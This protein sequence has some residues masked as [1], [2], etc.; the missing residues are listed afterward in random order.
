MQLETH[1]KSLIRD[2]YRRAVNQGDIAFAEQLIADDYIQHSNAMKP[3]KAGIIEALTF[4][5]Q[6]PKPASAS[7]PYFRLIA[8]SDF[9]V[10]NLSFDWEGRQ[11]VVVD[12]FRFDNGKV[13]EHWDAVQDQ[14]ETSLNGHAMMDGPLPIVDAD[15][16]V[17]NKKITIEFFQQIFIGRQLDALPQFV[18]TDLVQ[19][20]PEIANGINGLQAFL[21]QN[22]SAI[23]RSVV[24]RIIAEGDFVVIQFE[25]TVAQKATMFYDIF[26]LR[27]GLIVEHW[28]VN[29]LIH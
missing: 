20:Q 18:A 9:V 1:N 22:A 4:M 25:G 28:S 6:M 5:K 24:H 8:E 13:A 17:T 3:G 2:F 10:T 12:L 14:P 23:S 11:K 15:L 7:T 27:Q 16:T 26:R 19:H 21:S 29:Q